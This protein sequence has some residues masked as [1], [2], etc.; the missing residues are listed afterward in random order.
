MTTK[1]RHKSVEEK[2]NDNQDVVDI[3]V[4]PNAVSAI[5]EDRPLERKTNNKELLERLLEIERE[6]IQRARTKGIMYRK[7][8]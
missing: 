2:Y 8:G 5:E 4:L 3:M 7:Q 6:I 1:K